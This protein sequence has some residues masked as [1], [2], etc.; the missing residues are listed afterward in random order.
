MQDELH[1]Q[2]AE[3]EAEEVRDNVT[4]LNVNRS[5]QLSI[6]QVLALSRREG[7]KGDSPA[8]KNR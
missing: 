1:R 2:Q 7:T 8:N 5:P 6:N 3:H 4:T